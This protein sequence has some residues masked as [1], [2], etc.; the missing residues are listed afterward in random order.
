MDIKNTQKPNTVHKIFGGASGTHAAKKERKGKKRKWPIILICVLLVLVCLYLTVV[1]SQ[2]PFIKNLRTMYIETAMSTMNHQW[3]A[4]WFFPPSVVQQVVD[5]MEQSYKDNMVDESGLPDQTGPGPV[6]PPDDTPEPPD[7]PDEPDPPVVT[8]DGGLADLLAQF[9]ELDPE[10]IPDSITDFRGL[11]I[12]AIEDMGIKT[13]AGDTVWA[14]DSP[15]NL[16]IIS[17]SNS[18]Y[19]GKLAIVKDSSQV[20]LGANKHSGRGSTVT[21][22]CKNYNA[23]LGINASGFADG[24][25]HGKGDVCIGLSISEG[26]KYSNTV[27]DTYQICGFDYDNNMR[28]GYK[29]DTSTLRD[30]VQFHPIIVLNGE[31]H[32]DGSFMSKQPRTCI[33]QTSDKS[34]LMLVIEGRSV[35]TGLGASVSTCA[36]ILLRYG[37]YNAMNMDGGSSSSMTYMN[38]MITKTSSPKTD[39]RY[40][41]NSWL[42]M[43]PST[44]VTSE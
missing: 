28:M 31:K 38:E 8:D 40:L 39:G 35:T 25:G 21:E 4:T 5:E 27:G 18:D 42:I 43:P 22:L 37:C 41:P 20:I 29:V 10:T 13:T 3:L 12:K 1:Y 6:T 30:A 19:T 2:I 11:Q 14:I 9:P 44:S 23:V 36:D 33:G 24:D 26:V 32:V 34:V 7:E 16:I 17:F 15:N